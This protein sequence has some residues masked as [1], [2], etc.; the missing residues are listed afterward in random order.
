MLFSCVFIRQNIV[1]YKPILVFHSVHSW[2]SVVS[3]LSSLGDS[4]V[5]KGGKKTNLLRIRLLTNEFLHCF[6]IPAIRGLD[7][8]PRTSNATCFVH[9]YMH[10][11]HTPHIYTHT[12]SYVQFR[13]L[14]IKRKC[15]IRSVPLLLLRTLTFNKEKFILHPSVCTCMHTM[16]AHT[17]SDSC[18]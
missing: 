6:R 12:Y 10:T 18:I 1:W 13:H 7:S 8:T 14:L 4:N 9:T 11:Q 5:H 2:T 16:H 15:R 3:F 17:C